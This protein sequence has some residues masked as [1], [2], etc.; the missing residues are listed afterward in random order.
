MFF[1]IKFPKSNHL[2]LRV[3]WERKKGRNVGGPVS[4][5]HGLPDVLP[6]PHPQHRTEAAAAVVPQGHRAGVEKRRG[7]LK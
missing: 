1:K 2:L 5:L 4:W 3:W 6:T 7:V